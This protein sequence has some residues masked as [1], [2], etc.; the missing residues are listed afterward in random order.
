MRPGE[1]GFAGFP[2][3]SFLVSISTA[4]ISRKQAT[5]K[6]R[7]FYGLKVPLMVIQTGGAKARPAQAKAGLQGLS[8]QKSGKPAHKAVGTD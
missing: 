3:Q 4:M 6:K 2:L 8:Y 7:Y 5:G 1:I